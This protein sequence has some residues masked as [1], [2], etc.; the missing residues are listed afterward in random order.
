MAVI[1]LYGW[2]ARVFDVVIVVVVD[3]DVSEH[4]ETVK[5]LSSLHILSE[6]S[7]T[8]RLP[9]WRLNEIFRK[10]L[11]IALTGGYAVLPQCVHVYLHSLFINFTIVISHQHYS[12]C[13]II[14]IALLCLPPTLEGRRLL[15]LPVYRL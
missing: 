6:Q 13:V 14:L 4:T 3:D 9:G 12:D 2:E 11:K 1:E 5:K 7:Q 8:G 15:G 10:N